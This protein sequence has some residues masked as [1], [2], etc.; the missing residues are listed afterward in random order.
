MIKQL[1][2]RYFELILF[3]LA[4]IKLDFKYLE[5]LAP[6]MELVLQYEAELKTPLWLNADIVIGPNSPRDPIPPVFI[7]IANR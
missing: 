1:S 7:D 3:E 2:F 4:G 5:A 6:S